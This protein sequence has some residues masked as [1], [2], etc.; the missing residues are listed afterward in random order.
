MTLSICI[1]ETDN[2]RPEL[3]EQYRGYGWMFQQLFARQPIEWREG[4]LPGWCRK[5]VAVEAG[6]TGYWRQ[7]VGLDGAVVGIDQFGASAPADKLFQHFG[8]T[9]DAVVDAAMSLG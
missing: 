8:I 9:V 6:V 5:R 2:I 4:V 1:L 7:F 3:V